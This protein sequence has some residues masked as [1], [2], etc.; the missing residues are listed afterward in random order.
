MTKSEV[1]LYNKDCNNTNN[2][3][4]IPTCSKKIRNVGK[5]AVKMQCDSN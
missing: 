5:F 2:N 1:F 4:Y 3:Y